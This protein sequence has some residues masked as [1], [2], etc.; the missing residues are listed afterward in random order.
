[1]PPILRA[2]PYYDHPSVVNAGGQGETV[3]AHQIVLWA[4]IAPIGQTQL[5]PGTPRFPVVLDTGFSGSF[6]ITPNQLSQWA[7]LNW[8]SLPY[9]P[10]L[11]LSYG[12][13]PVPH[14]RA[15]LWLFPN[16]RGWRDLSD[17][18][19]SPY[20]LQLHGGIAVYGNNVVVG[21]AATAQL[22]GPRLP[23]LGL[24]A[25]TPGRLQ[26]RLDAGNQSIDLDYP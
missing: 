12:G 14:R 20:L 7:A 16:Q 22:P 6:A 25:L 18:L 13:I 21:V 10:T 15:N 19:L 3:V 4:G 23:I 24:R 8:A 26:L 11:K 17:P 5:V 9:D 1:M 2:L